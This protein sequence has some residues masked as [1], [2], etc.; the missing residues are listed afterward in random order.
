MT[1]LRILKKRD[2]S[3]M[4]QRMGCTLPDCFKWHDDPSIPIVEEPEPDKELA[5]VLYQNHYAL[6][7]LDWKAFPYKE[8]WIRT[9][10]AAKA[11]FLAH[12]WREPDEKS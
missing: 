12:G 4:G 11:W 8:I 10:Q 2:G 1:N 3:V 9:A 5:Q 6:G 7:E